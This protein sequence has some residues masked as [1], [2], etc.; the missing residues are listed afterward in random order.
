MKR[1]ILCFSIL[2]ICQSFTEIDWG[3]YGH[4][5]INRLAVF[6]LPHEMLGFYKKN[7]E[8]ITAH[9]V[10]PDKRRYAIKNEATR[11]YI[12]IDHFD[13]IPFPD[14]PRKFENAV[15]KYGYISLI[16]SNG[17]T[18]FD[19]S[20]VSNLLTDRTIIDF[21]M[22]DRYSNEIEL[23]KDLI[24][25]SVI[26]ENKDI[27]KVLFNNQLAAYG[28]LPFFLEEFYK[29][30]VYAFE[31][32]KTHSIL[33]ISADIGHYISDA[34]VPLHTTVNY[35]GQLTDQLG[36]HA[37]WESRLPEL[38]AE[39]DYDFLVG[40]AQYVDDI[41]SYIWTVII[42]SHA[43]LPKV[44]QEEAELRKKFRSELQF[45]FDE[46]SDVTQRLQCPEYSKAYHESLNGMVEERMRESISAIGNF[47]Y[48]A[49]I[50][51][52]QPDLNELDTYVSGQQEEQL[53]LENSN[54]T[55]HQ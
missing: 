26:K 32:R 12:D 42:G 6:T 29:R 43:H 20:I 39:R 53:I 22:E 7:I 37:F 45:C 36:I 11:H 2:L 49:W 40:Q 27:N 8:Y 1:F 51:A 14:V 21:I 52:G 18:L 17:D 5:K 28:T 44:L 33:K 13:T 38:F 10:D 30:L 16:S 41:Q 24:N 35:N 46:R 3:F 31:S 23:P 47:W 34:H 54:S 9:A 55:H 48:S 15:L 4:K 50:D 19:E 25:L